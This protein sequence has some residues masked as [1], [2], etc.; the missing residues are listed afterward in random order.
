[1][2][3]RGIARLL[4]RLGITCQLSLEVLG[5]W[6][7]NTKG[8]CIGQDALEPL[9]TQRWFAVHVKPVFLG[10]FEIE[11]EALDLIH[12]LA[13]LHSGSPHQNRKNDADQYQRARSDRCIIDLEAGEN[14]QKTA[15]AIDRE[16]TN[17][18]GDDHAL[19]P[20]SAANGADKN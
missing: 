18:D 15:A 4:P 10:R 7:F 19:E 14:V 17:P 5:P 12:G 8:D 16:G 13:S 6:L 11:L 3:N 20:V 2:P 9:N 1:I